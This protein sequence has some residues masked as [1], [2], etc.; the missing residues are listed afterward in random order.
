MQTHGGRLY[1]MRTTDQ[2]LYWLLN[3]LY[4]LSPSLGNP[5]LTFHGS[6]AKSGCSESKVFQ[7][8][9]STGCL[10]FPSLV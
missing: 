6:N 7:A 5:S 1:D 2:I 4:G 10:N 8:S 9:E 3:V